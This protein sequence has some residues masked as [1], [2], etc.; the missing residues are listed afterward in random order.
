MQVEQEAEPRVISCD[1]VDLLDVFRLRDK[2]I[3]CF[4]EKTVTIIRDLA[5]GLQEPAITDRDGA[6]ERAEDQS[7]KI[8]YPGVSLKIQKIEK[9]NENF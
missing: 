5:N 3:E 2:V 9:N 1:T 7:C 6:G 8:A 4:G